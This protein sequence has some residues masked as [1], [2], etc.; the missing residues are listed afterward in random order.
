MISLRQAIKGRCD[1]EICINFHRSIRN[2]IKTGYLNLI[3]RKKRG[4]NSLT[5]KNNSRGRTE[6][7]RLKIIMM[8][9]ARFW[10]HFPSSK[11]SLRRNFFHDSESWPV[12][13]PITVRLK[14]GFEF[15]TSL[16]DV[17]AWV[18]HFN[19]VC[20]ASIQVVRQAG[21]FSQK[22]GRHVKNRFEIQWIH[23]GRGI[24]TESL[25]VRN[26]VLKFFKIH[27]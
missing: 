11:P 24:R 15:Q 26:I 19:G 13:F 8:I 14:I 27:P 5:R 12:G 16:F 7:N 20:F 17:I 9:C 18:R 4:N 22:W 2:L 21:G 23:V 25:D 6:F 3:R 1:S 10:V